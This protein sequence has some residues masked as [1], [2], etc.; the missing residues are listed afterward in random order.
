ME[1]INGKHLK[2]E[3]K[4]E[5]IY[6]FDPLC[7]WCYGFSPVMQ[8]IYAEFK[9]D[10]DF[11]VLSGGMITG[12]RVGPIG[13][14]APYIKEAY[15][16]VE[17]T[18]GVKFGEKFLNEILAKGEAVFNSALPARALATFRLFKPHE[19]LAFA[20]QL[21]KAIYYDGINLYHDESYGQIAEGFGIDL[22]SFIQKMK[23]P[24]IE[25]IVNNEFEMVAGMGIRAFPSVV[26]RKGKEL[27]LI[28]TGYKDYE[29]MRDCLK[30]ESP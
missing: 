15:K 6:I 13:L 4:P 18:T 25:E 11:L 28:S 7:G 21:Q 3:E 14:V 23:E 17:Q 30:E 20:S 27:S 24:Q 16:S 1:K 2:E 12:D 5:V 9:S 19:S 10:Y 22:T 29:D 8:K 26:L